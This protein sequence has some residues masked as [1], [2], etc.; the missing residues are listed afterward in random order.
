MASQPSR[1]LRVCPVCGVAMLATKSD[2][3]SEDVDTFNCLRCNTVISLAPEQKP[4][5]AGGCG[6]PQAD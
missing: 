1:A 6:T 3:A 5:K 4:P 2:A